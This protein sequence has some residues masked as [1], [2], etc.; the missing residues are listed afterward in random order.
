VVSIVKLVNGTEIIGDV[1]QDTEKELVV[2]NA[3][4]VNYRIRQDSG[5]PMV[6]LHKYIPFA[7]EDNI[8][9]SKMQVLN[10]V[11]PLPGM[12]KYYI[13]VLDSIKEVSESINSNLNEA[14][15]EAS[16]EDKIT[17]AMQE[18]EIFKPTLN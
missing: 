7:G 9:F 6:S 2:N 12:I 8:T 16:K 1:I 5:F 4:Q 10:R 17:L 18:K 3:L 11:K 14:S 13:Q 15:E